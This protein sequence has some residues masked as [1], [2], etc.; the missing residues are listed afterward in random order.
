MKKALSLLLTLCLAIGTCIT[1][2]A[3]EK[4]AVKFSVYQG[5][6]LMTPTEIEVDAGISDRYAAQVGYNDTIGEPTILDALIAA[7]IEIFGED[8][9]DVLECNSSGWITTAFYQPGSSVTYHQNG[10]A[11]ASLNT[12]VKNGDYIDFAF[13][14]DPYYTD[15]YCSFDI[16]EAT[17]ETGKSITLTATGEGYD[18]SW[19]LVKSPLAE[20]EITVNDEPYGKTDS[21]GRI[22]LSFDECGTYEISTESVVNGKYVFA[23]F[24]LVNAEE[25]AEEPT[26]PANPDKPQNINSSP[27]AAVKNSPN[28]SIVE[29]QMVAAASFLTKNSTGFDVSGSINFLTYINSTKDLSSFKDAFLNDVKNNLKAGNGRLLV[30]GNESIGAYGAVI[31]ILDFYGLDPADFEGYNLISAFENMDISQPADNPYLYRTAIKAASVHNLSND[32]AEALCRSLIDNFY[33]FDKGMDYYGFSCDNTAQFITALSPYY[34]TYKDV[35][36][37]AFTVLETYKGTDG[38]F[39]N[40]TYTNVNCNS[41]AAALMAYASVGNAEKAAEIYNQ[42]CKFEKATGEFSYD[43]IEPADEFSTRDALLAL[44]YYYPLLEDKPETAVNNNKNDN[45]DVKKNT[46]KTSPS[47]G[48]ETAVLALSFAL[49][50]AGMITLAAKKKKQ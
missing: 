18:S 16:R 36:D 29:K 27:S 23:P 7:N 21:S 17:V 4:T 3:D 34:D 42:L 50:G 13:Y 2:L 48:A 28:K 46:S 37:N 35:M 20:A 24:A 32:F 30:D 43:K 11:P 14:L 1:A 40:S 9:T 6:Y 39:Y 25:N 10:T 22:T 15:M 38:Y 49:A 19:N 45:K 41:T 12:A 47:T 44:E 33:T 26:V 31:Q 8:L 5:G